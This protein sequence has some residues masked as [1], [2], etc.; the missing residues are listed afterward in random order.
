MMNTTRIYLSEARINVRFSTYP[1]LHSL[2]SFS[3]GL[4]RAS[5]LEAVSYYGSWRMVITPTTSYYGSWRMVI[6]PLLVTMALGG[7]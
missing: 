1:R 7:W 5:L 2:R 3:L 4:L 6:P